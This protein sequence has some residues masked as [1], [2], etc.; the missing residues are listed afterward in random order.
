[1]SVEPKPETPVLQDYVHPCAAELD[2]G[3]LIV[4]KRKQKI[5]IFLFGLEWF[6]KCFCGVI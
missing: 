6:Y 3:M 2:P 5:L 1:M 4:E